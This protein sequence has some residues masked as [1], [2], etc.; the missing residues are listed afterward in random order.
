MI[1]IVGWSFCFGS[2]YLALLALE[3]YWNFFDWFPRLDL[4]GSGLAV[5]VLAALA[6]TYRLA[7]ISIDRVTRIF[8]LMGCLALFVLGAYVL[9][10]EPKT[11]GLLARQ[12][13]SPLWYR[14]ARFVVLSCPSLFWMGTRP[15]SRIRER[16]QPGF[17][18]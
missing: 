10:A 3:L 6:G 13:P 11:Q 2:L 18:E 8:S 16:A 4:K 7:R 17:S 15:R 12:S 9:P 14:G 5:A 1:L